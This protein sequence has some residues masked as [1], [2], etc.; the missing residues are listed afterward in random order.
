MNFIKDQSRDA[1]MNQSEPWRKLPWKER[2]SIYSFVQ[3]LSDSY[4]YNFKILINSYN[5][6]DNDKNNTKAHT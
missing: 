4:F 5:N 6:D 1:P 2:D 3:S